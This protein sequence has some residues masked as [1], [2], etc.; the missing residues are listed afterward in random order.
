MSVDLPPSREESCEKEHDRDEIESRLPETNCLI[1]G[2]KF[3]F[4][5]GREIVAGRFGAVYEVR[6]AFSMFQT[7]FD[8]SNQN[9]LDLCM[10]EPKEVVPQLSPISCLS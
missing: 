5:I 3:S 7:F 6:P 1:R 4:A 8:V 10:S 9:I 2:K